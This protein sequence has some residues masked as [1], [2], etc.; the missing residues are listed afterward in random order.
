[1]KKILIPG[2]LLLMLAVNLA[3]INY[4]N[5]TQT[6]GK[7]ER[8]GKV[9][10]WGLSKRNPGVAPVP[11]PGA[12]ELL[13]EYNGIYI[14]DTQKNKIYITFD[15][16][17]E[18]G[19]TPKI[20]DVL[21]LNDVKAVFFITGHYLKENRELVNRML[22]EGHEVGNHGMMHKSL[23]TLSEEGIKKEVKDLNDLFFEEFNKHM[24]FIRPPRGEY[25]ERSL[26]IT[27]EMGYINVFWSFAYQD[28]LQD[29]IRGE[30]YAF[31]EVSKYFH[32]GE[33]ILLHAV[34]P[35]NAYALDRI[36]KN[37]REKGYEFGKLEELVR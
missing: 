6:S 25:S 3:K 35:D 30:D 34:S 27:Q 16:G 14:G 12:P 17:Y 29:K 21:Q 2:L 7:V 23:P 18:N 20:L 24:R 22:D 31:N 1:M 19:Y 33:I 28:W 13:K 9:T 15:Q 5:A 32:N 8:D 10:G 37:A 36:I 26:R 11:D 4:E